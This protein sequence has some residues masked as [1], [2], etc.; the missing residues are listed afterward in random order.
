MEFTKLGVKKITLTNKQAKSARFS[1]LQGDILAQSSYIAP[2]SELTTK[3]DSSVT[4]RRTLPKKIKKGDSVAVVFTTYIPENFS[5]WG[6]VL[7]N[8]LPAGLKFTGKIKNL[9]DEE[10]YIIPVV[11]GQKISF[12]Q[13][14]GKHQFIVYCKAAYA[15]EFQYEP[16]VITNEENTR[17]AVSSTQNVKILE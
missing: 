16:S 3:A 12:W 1:A 7:T 9:G 10:D 14:S 4:I 17:Y 2:I 6:A 11:D 5:D 15:G 8:V 13:T